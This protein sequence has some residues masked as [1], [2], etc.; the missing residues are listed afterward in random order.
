MQKHYRDKV[1]LITGGS[2]GIGRSLAGIAAK[3]GAR[4]CI[5]ARTE[6][7]LKKTIEELNISSSTRKDHLYFATDL[8][9]Y[10]N[11]CR[12]AE[13]VT[14]HTGGPDIII[15]S[16]GA[17]HPG[18]FEELDEN[19]FR[20]MMEAN[21][22]TTVNTIKA[23]M[24]VMIKKQSG[25]IVNISS[26][27][28]YLGV[29]GYTAYGASKFAITGLSKTLHA[30]MKRH[31]IKVSVVYPPDTHTPQYDYENQFKPAETKAISGTAKALH[32]DKVAFSILKQIKNGGFNIHP[33][34][35]T[36]FFYGLQKMLPDSLIFYILDNLSK[37][38]KH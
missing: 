8:S 3:S 29:F 35:D 13:Y 22:F 28:G 1:L 16:A 36:A 21:Y 27:A 6:D 30:E 33:S 17:A 18:Y 25:H 20:W 32:P 23:F 14:E 15:N 4:V 34:F 19:I 12:M 24:P 5:T 2:S 26:V 10:S 38:K 31:K 9:N 7:T 37:P 11:A